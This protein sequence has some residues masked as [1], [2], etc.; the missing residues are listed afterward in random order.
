MKRRDNEMH[1][2]SETETKKEH[3]QNE[4]QRGRIA[5]VSR[6]QYR[7]L[8]DGQ[9]IPARL[10][11]GFYDESPERFPVVGDYV[12]FFYNRSGDSVI[13]SV[14]ER[15]S[16]LQRPDQAK[17]GVMQYMAANADYTFI[18]TA[19]NHDYSY[20]R[21]ARYASVALQGGSVPVVILTKADLCDD[22][23][24]YVKE[25]ETISDKVRVHAISALR[26]IGMDAL[27]E[28]FV[29]G[30]TIC[31]LG[32][33]GA[34]KSTLINAVTGEE[35]METSEVRESDSKGRHTTTHRQLLM[36]GDGVCIID[37][38]GMREI[39]MAGVQEGIEDT[40]SDILELESRCRFS[41]CR[42]ETEPGCAVRAAIESGE[43]SA[44]RY[45]LYR[46][47]GA[48]NT[49]N[50]AKKKEISKWAKAYRKA[51]RKGLFPD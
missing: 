48:E 19:L 25:A 26:G 37:T 41:D 47:L 34:G 2:N 36:T 28:Y 51:S 42:H 18:V 13:R 50:Y 15:S 22:A 29:P 46:N 23:D 20:N 27:K 14:C 45:E 5:C 7:I 30:K 43:L 31:L 35:I 12:T 3:R 16:F 17:T 49:R 33:S 44:E 6:N 39:G 32:S 4:E 1:M 24:R 10:G 38:P 8:F 21:I 40:F 9:E 11:G